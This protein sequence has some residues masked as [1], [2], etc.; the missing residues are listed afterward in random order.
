M[1]YYSDARVS[2]YQVDALTA[3][4]IAECSI[5]SF[6]T[7]PPAGIKFMGHAWD[8]SAGGRTAWVTWATTC[9]TGA[10]R[11][12]KPGAY[13]LVWALP[14]RS[15]WTAW[16]LESAGFEVLDVVHHLFGEGWPKNR[17]LSVALDKE[18]G[19][20]RPVIGVK[21]NTYDGATRKPETHSNPAADSSFGKWGLNKTPHGLPLT[22]PVTAAAKQ[23]SGWGTAL[24]PAVE[25]WILVR[26]PITEKTLAANLR[27]HGVGGLNIEAC[28]LDSGRWPANLIHD[29]EIM[30]PKHAIFFYA[31]KP[32]K[33]ERNA[34]CSQGNNHPTVKPLA[35]MRYLVRL[36][37]PPNGRVLD[38]FMGSGTTGVAAL[39][40]GFLFTGFEANADYC[41]IAKDRI[42]SALSQ[43]APLT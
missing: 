11:A 28:K 18:A 38:I 31:A 21:N 3:N 12:L 16:A 26:K 41:V 34:G 17:D 43:S 20:V 10:F 14:R 30:N 27:K 29:G 33:K 23:W 2:L 5:S 37:T 15:H 8:D 9:F 36:I 39:Q 25:Q 35:L 22:A 40:E 24:K 4:V 1:L 6:V 13:G 42:V 19:A 32:S 7:D